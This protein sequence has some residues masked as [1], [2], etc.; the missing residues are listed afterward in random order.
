MN[1]D[2]NPQP[3]LSSRASLS[4][5]SRKVYIPQS[6]T[7]QV[8]DDWTREKHLIQAD[9]IIFLHL[10]VKTWDPDRLIQIAPV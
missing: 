8:T 10:T 9:P 1:R 2:L 7:L 3:L 4:G 6:L 5:S